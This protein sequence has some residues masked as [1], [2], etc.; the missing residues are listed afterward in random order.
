MLPFYNGH[1]LCSA[2]VMLN[3]VTGEFP[4][5]G[6]KVEFA[7]KCLKHS[8]AASSQPPDRGSLKQTAKWAIFKV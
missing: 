6:M 8:E 1:T 2:S 3:V 4:P 5:V 7:I